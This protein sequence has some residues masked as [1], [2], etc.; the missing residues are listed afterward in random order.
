MNTQLFYFSWI[1][2]ICKSFAVG[3]PHFGSLIQMGAIDLEEKKTCVRR[4]NRLFS[5][6]FVKFWVAASCCLSAAVALLLAA[7]L[8]PCSWT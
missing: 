3:L 4:F 8:L 2:L 1:S 5:V 6:A 7:G